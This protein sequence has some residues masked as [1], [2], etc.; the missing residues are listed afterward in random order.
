MERVGQFR[1][2]RHAISRSL[3][4]TD[5]PRLDPH[6]PA[7]GLFPFRTGTKGDSPVG[8]TP[9]SSPQ[10]SRRDNAPGVRRH[11]PTATETKR[12]RRGSM[13]IMPNYCGF[14]LA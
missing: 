8:A 6:D 5:D 14:E 7:Y 10:P 11:S 2:R 12:R 1:R 13:I 9:R 4:E 3:F